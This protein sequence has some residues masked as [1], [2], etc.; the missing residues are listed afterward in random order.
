MKERINE[1]R[2]E[3]DALDKVIVEALVKRINCVLDVVKYKTNEEEVRGCDRV[4]IVLDK[5]R[6]L[7]T[8]YG[9]NEDIIVEIYKTIIDI[10]TGMQLK[11]LA[12]RNTPAANTAK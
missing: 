2:N 9:G 11:I 7:A 5:V 6:R 8:E 3:I 1:K 4:Q 10:L 12:E